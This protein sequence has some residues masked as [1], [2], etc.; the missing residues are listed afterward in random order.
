MHYFSNFPCII[1]EVSLGIKNMSKGLESGV[2]LTSAEM[3]VLQEYTPSIPG[4]LHINK[5]STGRGLGLWAVRGPIPQGTKYGPFLGN[6]VQEPRNPKYAW[7]VSILSLFTGR[8]QKGT[9]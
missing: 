1:L 5:S 9:N 3:L 4:E 6:W 8:P 7:E 2:G